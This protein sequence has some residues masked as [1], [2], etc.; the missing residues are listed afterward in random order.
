MALTWRKALSRPG[1][2]GDPNGLKWDKTRSAGEEEWRW[3]AKDGG[4]TALGCWS[5]PVELVWLHCF[6]DATQTNMGAEERVNVGHK[7]S[8]ETQ[9][10][11]S[12]WNGSP[13]VN[14]KAKS[15]FESTAP[16]QRDIVRV[17]ERRNRYRTFFFFFRRT[18]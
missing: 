2:D 9:K 3:K 16:A 1:R 5:G 11:K 12:Y 18:C 7:Q 15:A 14:W 4:R 6:L 13:A 10:L 17:G 8:A